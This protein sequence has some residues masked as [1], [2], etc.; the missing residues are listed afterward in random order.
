MNDVKLW[1]SPKNTLK[2]LGSIKPC[3]NVLVVV[4][5]LLFHF[6]RNNHVFDSKFANDYILI[7]PSKD[8]TDSIAAVSI[9]FLEDI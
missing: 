3:F 9:M 4:F 2:S 6:S 7:I 5:S 1:K 8:I